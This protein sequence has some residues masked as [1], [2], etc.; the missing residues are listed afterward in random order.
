MSAGRAATA[1]K[2]Q[3]VG[4]RTDNLGFHFLEWMQSP[5]SSITDGVDVSKAAARCD[6][7]ASLPKVPCQNEVGAHHA[8]SPRL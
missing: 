4:N 8:G 3:C 6:S 1:R 5:A 7:A 2:R